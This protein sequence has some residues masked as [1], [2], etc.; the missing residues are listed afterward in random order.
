MDSINDNCSNIQ[1][2]KRL[3]KNEVFSRYEFKREFPQIIYSTKP[4]QTMNE[5]T[6]NNWSI[7]NI[8]EVKKMLYCGIPI[9]NS[10][11]LDE[12]LPNDINKIL[13]EQ[14]NFVQENKG[15]YSKFLD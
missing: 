4:Q 1:E 6:C 3:L 9:R 14:Y 7:A 15:T 10:A 8:D 13:E 12:I 2:F 5:Y 11:E